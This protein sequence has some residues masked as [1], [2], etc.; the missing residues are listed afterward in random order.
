MEERVRNE[1]VLV[2]VCVPVYNGAN[3]IEETIK[4]IIDQTYKNIEIIVVDNCSTD[5]T[6]SILRAIDDERL[7]I[8][9]NDSNLGMEGNWNPWL[10]V[11]LN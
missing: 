1:E 11:H 3:T 2:S 5:N 8:Y 9:V 10:L 6:V 7:K 4:S